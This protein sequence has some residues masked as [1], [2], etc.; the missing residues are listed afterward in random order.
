[1]PH[2]F[3]GGSERLQVV[4]GGDESVAVFAIV[5][6]LNGYGSDSLRS[7]GLPRV[8][9]TGVP[10]RFNGGS[11]RLQVVGGGDESVAMFAIVRFLNGYGSDSLRSAGLPRVWTTGVPHRF[12]GG[13]ERLQ[14]VGGGD[15][16]EA[17]FVIVRFLTGTARIVARLHLT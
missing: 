6:F 2:R 15:E 8:W 10:H 14:V 16:S 17:V 5:R 9:S 11:E 12:N 7:A 3:N 1:V 4:G 13:S